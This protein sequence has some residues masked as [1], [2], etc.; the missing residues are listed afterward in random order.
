M[1]G[2]VTTRYGS[3]VELCVHY[4]SHILRHRGAPRKHLLIVCVRQQWITKHDIAAPA[5]A[6]EEA[7]LCLGRVSC[8]GSSWKN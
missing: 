5:G 7:M 1:L 2:P 3:F 4:R 6:A 8:F